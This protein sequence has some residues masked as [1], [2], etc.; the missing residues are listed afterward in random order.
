MLGNRFFVFFPKLFGKMLVYFRNTPPTLPSKAFLF[1]TDARFPGLFYTQFVRKSQ[2]MRLE[3]IGE[4]Y[5]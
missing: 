5:F 3:K 2:K 4:N 1:I